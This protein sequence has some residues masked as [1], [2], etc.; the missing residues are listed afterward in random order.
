MIKS[1]QE[2]GYTEP[3]SSSIWSENFSE[4]PLLVSMYWKLYFSFY[5]AL[6]NSRNGLFDHHLGTNSKIYYSCFSR[7][8]LGLYCCPE[9]AIRFSNDRFSTY[10]TF[11]E[12]LTFFRNVSQHFLGLRNISLTENVAYVLNI[13]SFNYLKCINFRE[14]LFPRVWKNCILEGLGVNESSGRPIFI[15][16]IKE[17]WS[18]FCSV[19]CLRLQVVQIKQADY[20]ISTNNV[21]NYK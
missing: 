6:K 2:K 13:W 18:G 17:N 8:C 19:V 10:A 9:A 21:N 12:K 7:I 15:V 20:K 14:Q 3:L 1:I 5:I 16:F 11:F 4:F